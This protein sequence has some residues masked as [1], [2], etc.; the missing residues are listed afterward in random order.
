M[1]FPARCGRSVAASVA[2]VTIAVGRHRVSDHLRSRRLLFSHRADL[3][4]HGRVALWEAWAVQ[5]GGA[6]K[7]TLAEYRDRVLLVLPKSWRENGITIRNDDVSSGRVAPTCR[8]A[9]RRNP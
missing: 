5:S 8:D 1:G 9:S 7:N 4:S 2:D 3:S 6:D